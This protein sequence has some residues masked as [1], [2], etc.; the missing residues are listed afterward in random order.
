MGNDSVNGGAGADSISGG[1]GNDTIYAGQGDTVDAGNDNDLILLDTASGTPVTIDGGA[2]IDTVRLMGDGVVMASGLNLANVEY[3]DLNG[4]TLSLTKDFNLDG[5]A[6]K[7]ITVTNGTL[8]LPV[9]ATSISGAS[10]LLPN[11]D[12]VVIGGSV[13]VQTRSDDIFTN[14]GGFKVI[15]AD[16]DDKAGWSVSSAGDVNAD[17]YEDFLVGAPSSDLDGTGNNTGRAYVV[18]GSASGHNTV[19][20]QDIEDRVLVAGKVKGFAVTGET[21]GDELGVS[22]TALGDIN[23]DGV[24]DFAVGASLADTSNKGVNGSA[25]VVYG[26]ANGDTDISAKNIRTDSSLGFVIDGQANGDW[27][28][29]VVSNAGDVNGDGINDLLVTSQKSD[30]NGS[31]SGRAYVVFGSSTNINVELDQLGTSGKGFEIKGGRVGDH[32]GVSATGIGDINGDGFAD[33]LI[34]ANEVDGTN[35]SDVGAAYVVYGKVSSTAVDM[36]SFQTGTD[37]FA[38]KGEVAWDTLGQSVAVIGDVNGDGINDFAIGAPQRNVGP[39]NDVGRTYVVFGGANSTDITLADLEAG[40]GGFVINGVGDWDRSGQSVASVGDLNGDGLAD[41]II[42]ASKE[43][44]NESG[45]AYVVFGKTGGTAVNLSDVAAGTGGFFIK[46]STN[47]GADIFG[48]SVASAGDLNGDGLDD[49]IVGAPQKD[50][51][52][53]GSDTGESYVI[54]GSATGDNYATAFDWVGDTGN[55]TY[56][57]YTSGQ[58]L[59]AGAGNDTITTHGANVVYAGAGDD[60]V[61]VDQG[62]A[63]ALQASGVQDGVYARVDGGGGN[64]KLALTNGADLNLTLVANQGMGHSRIE[65]IETIDLAT[66]TSANTLTLSLKDVM[67]INEGTK[68]TINGGANDTVDLADLSLWKAPTT[69]VEGGTTYNVYTTV[70]P[71]TSAVELW[72]QDGIQV[73]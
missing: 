38:I 6:N 73:I 33:L 5:A 44:T 46:P 18:F 35:G 70:S 19:N 37:G 55:N 3:L 56:A 16:Y 63:T 47:T 25:Y 69:S 4:K 71:T 31:D 32:F 58:S 45:A 17:G 61:H 34:G 22:V 9:N 2:G 36:A 8:S 24:D 52:N 42:G 30:V 51:T 21:G 53:V 66:D 12:T 28:G 50:V 60:T 49:F 59:L 65:S 13:T 7:S 23:G 68:L 54:F 10:Y 39:A 27:A 15:G 29:S 14:S 40:T 11:G 20:L 26:R 1:N 57:A 67:D 62:M 72:V 64:D 48:F 41:M 43:G